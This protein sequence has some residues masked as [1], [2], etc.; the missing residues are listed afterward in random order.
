MGT[1][2][3]GNN[4]SQL[5]LLQADPEDTDYFYIYNCHFE[6]Y[7]I[8]KW[9]SGDQKVGPYNGQFYDAQ[10]WKFV[11]EGNG[12][13]RI[14]NKRYPTAKMAKWGKGDGDWGTY[15]GKNYQSQLWKLQPRFTADP[16]SAGF[17]DV[18]WRADN[19]EG[20]NEV[21]QVITVS[22]GLKLSESSSVRTLHGLKTSLEASVAAGDF[23]A[24]L[25]TEY[26]M[27]I[28]NT[29]TTTEEKNWV[30]TSQV[31]FI[32]P[33][34]KIYRVLQNVVKFTS[35]LAGDNFELRCNHKIEEEEGEEEEE[36]EE[37]E[38]V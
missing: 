11:D 19:R 33:P 29:D 25:T 36:E 15:D 14:Y 32:A 8:G 30:T 5:W 4:L 37:D 24:T 31:T 20:S 6:G 35:V 22:R 17:S 18:L 27:E 3:Q 28:E 23:S 21:T 26:N 1:H 9:D 10:L 13:Y 16:S 2:E 12:Y 34:G 7:R 38:P